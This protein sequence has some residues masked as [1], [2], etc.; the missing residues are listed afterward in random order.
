MSAYPC[1]AGVAELFRGSNLRP[2]AI[3]MSLMLLQQITG[4]PSVLYYA[5]RSFPHSLVTA[6]LAADMVRLTHVYELQAEIFRQA[7][8]ASGQESTG[9][10]VFLGFFKLIATGMSPMASC[11]Q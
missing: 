8:F 7:G 6:F 5:V 3:G 11:S 4:Q 2:L 10:S 9:V 1:P